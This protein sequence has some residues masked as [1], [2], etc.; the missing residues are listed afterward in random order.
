MTESMQAIKD[1]LHEL[2]QF[3]RSGFSY[4]SPQTITTSVELREGN[5]YT[6]LDPTTTRLRLL[7]SDLYTEQMIKRPLQAS[8]YALFT[9]LK[10]DY[11]VPKEVLTWQPGQWHM[12]LK[13]R[14]GIHIGVLPKVESVMEFFDSD[15]AGHL[16]LVT[17]VSDEESITLESIGM[18]E[19]GV[20][21]TH[22][23]PKQSWQTFGPVFTSFSK[24]KKYE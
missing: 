20:F 12:K 2:W 19:P 15:G 5:L 24:V 16:G 9:L 22:I 7:V 13:G 21:E 6:A 3:V 11:E 18:H 14:T 10:R 1:V 23:I 4:Q 17:T 8:E